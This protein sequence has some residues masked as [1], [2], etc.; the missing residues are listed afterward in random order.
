MKRFFSRF[1]TG[2]ATALPNPQ[3]PSS[4]DQE[5][6]REKPHLTHPLPSTDRPPSS[7]PYSSHSTSGRRVKTLAAKYEAQSRD[8]QDTPRSTRS[9]DSA[10]I[11]SRT[12]PGQTISA[13]ITD[14]IISNAPPSDSPIPSLPPTFETSDTTP[15]PVPSKSR[16]A[17]ATLPPHSLPRRM[18][19]SSLPEK[20]DPQRQSIDRDA[21]ND[22]RKVSK[23]QQRQ[24]SG[25]SQ[26]SGGTASGPKTVAFAPSP[27]K[28]SAAQ[29]TNTLALRPSSP[30][31]AGLSRANTTETSSR[32]AG[33]STD[34]F[35]TNNFARP[36]AA[37][38]ARA[39]SSG[40]HS[41]SDFIIG[42][43]SGSSNYA[44]DRTL[45]AAPRS[46]KMGRANSLNTSSRRSSGT[47]VQDGPAVA[48]SS[49]TAMGHHSTASTSSLGHSYISGKRQSLEA[50]SIPFASAFHG[51]LI[52][53]TSSPMS[54]SGHGSVAMQLT[55]SGTGSARPDSIS[56]RGSMTPNSVGSWREGGSFP[57]GSIG[58][59]TM[60]VPSWSEMTQEELVHNLGPRERTRQEVL[61]EIVASEER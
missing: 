53:R 39:R 34:T 31:N 2:G 4:Q 47:G 32:L 25:S 28:P 14:T 11:Q 13:P 40:R 35:L 8:V 3:S 33:Q 9:P 49:P 52:H 17:L 19:G 36:T 48:I 30:H 5:W 61:W 24:P 23:E 18:P 26:A 59:K 20:Q 6:E 45:H 43:V 51:H 38:Q 15:P 60:G 1:S 44:N 57:F 21:L 41:G 55:N 54:A 27:E 58:S 50:N 56:R 7:T 37:S 16:A 12:D 46:V 10:P 42:A 29:V 22:Q